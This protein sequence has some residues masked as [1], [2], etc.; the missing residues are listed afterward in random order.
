MKQLSIRIGGLLAFVLF[1]CFSCTDHAPQPETAVAPVIKTIETRLNYK[2]ENFYII[3]A[4]LENIGSKPIKE[5]GI[6][7]SLRFVNN[8]SF[9][10]VP[11]VSDT[12]VATVSNPDK[13]G[14]YKTGHNLPVSSFERMYYRAYAILSDDSIVYGN[15]LEYIWYDTAVIEAEPT[16]SINGFVFA[17]IDV[18]EL[19]SLPIAEYGVVYVYT[20]NL[21]EQL[22]KDPDLSDN[23]VVFD[24]PLALGK[25]SKV[26]PINA[27]ARVRARSY[28]KYQNGVI[29]Y[30]KVLAGS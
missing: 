14:S 27:P 13:A 5:I 11:T 29:E 19:G 17:K 9:H 18:R 26:L 23:K 21:S 1:F 12:K 20:N 4:E 7:Y 3:G 25:H 8:P 6:V 16:A 24:L 30:G 10:A 15:I 22:T 28:I 2:P